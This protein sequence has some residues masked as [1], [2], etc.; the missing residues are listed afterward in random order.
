LER[1]QK[2]LALLK[3]SFEALRL[4]KELLEKRI[5]VAT[6]A[7]APGPDP[8]LAE[9]EKKLADARQAVQTTEAQVAALQREKAILQKARAD[10][11]Q[12]LA[13]AQA[14]ANRLRNLDIEQMRKLERE[15]LEARAATRDR[16][17]KITAL[18]GERGVLEAR[19]AALISEREQELSKRGKE[20]KKLKELEKEK[21][22]LQ[23][24]LNDATKELYA[25]R[26]RS[27]N[28]RLDDLN[29]QLANLRA[30]VEAYEMKRVPLTPE[31]LA[32][33]RAPAPRFPA[34]IPK[35]PVKELPGNTKMLIAEAQTD[36]SAGRLK[37]AEQKYA[38]VLKVDDKHV[39]TLYKLAG[40]MLD[41]DKYAEAEKTVNQG[42]ALE[43][44]NAGL[45]YQLGI[46]RYHQGKLDES[47]ALLSRSIKQNSNN[48]EVYNYLGFVL[49]K[50]GM[51]NEAE[52]A[53]RKAVQLEP[54]FSM[55]HL[56]LA[57]V[58]ANQKPPFLELSRW[59]YNK[60]VA[61]GQPRD[62]ELEKL[63]N[64]RP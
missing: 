48:A 9:A 41:Q 51:L 56:S 3:T 16:E 55:A 36:A 18:A 7:P 26:S 5:Q 44:D 22:R 61:D 38:E 6:S 39:Y 57:W 47:A 10:L 53:F 46:V 20:G 45:L 15:L 13:S 12:Q 11:E 4:E 21:E 50:K 54:G 42:L 30:R 23:N 17:Q 29:T 64:P 28:L 31:E 8:R 2:E 1:T 62:P 60:A 24:K 14:E 34:D 49:G 19:L 32:L 43:P 37:E 52:T 27:Y 58:Y 25:V 40:V 59:H 35:R 63:F 33:L